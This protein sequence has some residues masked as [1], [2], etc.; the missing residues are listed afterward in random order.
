MYA[1][2]TRGKRKPL[3]HKKCINILDGFGFSTSPDQG[4]KFGVVVCIYKA[5]TYKFHY[6]R[7]IHRAITR[8]TESKSS[9]E[10]HTVEN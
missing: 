3:N 2:E 4:N 10:L 6:K 9:I 1:Y 7:E 8:A 5:F